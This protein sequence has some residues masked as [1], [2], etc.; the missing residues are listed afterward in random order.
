MNIFG[1]KKIQWS[2]LKRKCSLAKIRSSIKYDGV[3]DVN[4][5]PLQTNEKMLPNQLLPG[6]FYGEVFL[7]F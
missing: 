7:V 2:I 5:I 3:Y 6:R 1:K 4:N